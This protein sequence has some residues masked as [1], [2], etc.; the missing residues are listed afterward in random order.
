[1]AERKSTFHFILELAPSR[2]SEFEYYALNLYR[3]CFG[4]P[5]I[6]NQKRF[7][8]RADRRFALVNCFTSEKIKSL[9]VEKGKR[10]LLNHSSHK[11]PLT[12]NAVTQAVKIGEGQENVEE[13]I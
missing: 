11:D 10:W 3:T 9:I 8:R 6:N 12:Y 1:L 2:K 4:Y 13:R 7:V 5:V